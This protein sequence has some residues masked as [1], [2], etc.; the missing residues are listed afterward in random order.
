VLVAAPAAERRVDRL[1]MRTRAFERDSAVIRGGSVRSLVSIPWEDP[2][3]DSSP[4]RPP[5]LRLL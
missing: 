2:P 1:T 4:P 3:D 5:K